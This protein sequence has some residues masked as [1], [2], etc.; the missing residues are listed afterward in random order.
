MP[1]AFLL[2]L[3]CAA[4]G[5]ASDLPEY[6]ILRASGP[7]VLDGRLDEPSWGAA[8]LIDQFLFPWWTAG[9]KERTEAR[10]LWDEEKLYVAFAAFD[11]HISAFLTQR[12]DPVSRDDCVEVFVAPDTS[13]VG[14][15]FNFEFNT[16][17]TIL[18]RSPRDDRTKDWNAQGLEVAIGVEG[19]LN[20]ETDID[21]LWVAEIAIP[22]AV[23]VGYA[24]R[25][26]PAPGEVWRL[27]LYRTGGQ[28]NLQ[29]MAWSDTRTADP[30]FHVPARFGVVRF[31]NAPATAVEDSSQV[32]TKKP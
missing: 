25:L 26:P 1:L 7:L 22:F 24:P 14:N 16:L 9:E 21:S 4:A 18:D 10:L 30:S 28:V 19:T 2:A 5:R 17:G 12:D 15:Y 29:Y 31:S 13:Q 20:H 23:F 27:N 6:T 32:K 8:P 3:L 11:P